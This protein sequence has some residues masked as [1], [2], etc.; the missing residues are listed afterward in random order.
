MVGLEFRTRGQDQVTAAMRGLAAT[1]Q[2]HVAKTTYHWSVNA[3]QRLR[4]TPYPPERQGQT[5]VR[6]GLLRRSWRSTPTNDGA[7]ITND[8]PGAV[9][10]IGDWMGGGQAWMHVGRWWTAEAILR[11]ERQKLGPM[12]IRELN[13]LMSM[14]Q[15]RP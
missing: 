12:I 1:G 3:I 8:R 14:G 5:Y 9:F 15:I 7:R 6:T 10:V 4:T 11:N 13:H 2:K